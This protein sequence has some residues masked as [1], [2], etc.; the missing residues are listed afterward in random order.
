MSWNASIGI[1]LL[2]AGVVVLALIYFFGLPRRPGQV[3]RMPFSRDQGA[4]DNGRVEPTFGE[5]PEQGELEV[6]ANAQSGDDALLLP[7]RTER[8]ASGPPRPAPGVRSQQSIDRIVTLFVAARSGATF[9][10]TDLIVAA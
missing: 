8:V 7:D 2:L 6:D 1:P 5:S 4:R 9:S 3:R 10:G